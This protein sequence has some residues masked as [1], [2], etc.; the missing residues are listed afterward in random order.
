MVLSVV[1]SRY[2]YFQVFEAAIGAE[3]QFNSDSMLMTVL[4]HSAKISYVQALTQFQLSLRD[5]N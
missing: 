4:S 1:H 5:N 2:I 3:A